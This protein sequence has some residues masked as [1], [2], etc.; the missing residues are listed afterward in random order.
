MDKKPVLLISSSQ[1]L[2]GAYSDDFAFIDQ[3]TDRVV[4]SPCTEESVA[5]IRAYLKEHPYI[6]TI[7]CRGFWYN[8]LMDTPELADNPSMRITRIDVDARVF[9][10]GF[11]ELT[12]LGY[13]NVILVHMSHY[14]DPD[15]PVSEPIESYGG[16]N[17][18]R[19]QFKTVEEGIPRFLDLVKRHPIDAI[20]GD[21]SDFDLTAYEELRAI[22]RIDY[23]IRKE[24]LRIQLLD[25]YHYANTLALAQANE[26]QLYDLKKIIQH[27]S[28]GII[29]FDEDGTILLHNDNALISRIDDGHKVGRPISDI[30]GLP[31]EEI[32]E[33]KA[34]SYMRLNNHGYIINVMELD[35]RDR[36]NYEM[37]LTSG[38]HAFDADMSARLALTKSKFPAR[39][40]FS[41]MIAVD[42]A[43]QKAVEAAKAFADY[44]ETVLI[45]GPTG[46]GKE[47]FASSIHNAS[48]RSNRPFVAINCATLSES[49]IDSELFGYEK[50]AFTGALTSGKHGLFEM[51]HRGT[52]FLDEISEIPIDLQTKLLRVLQ[53][54]TIRR[55]GGSEEIPIDVRIICATN[56]PLLKQCEKGLFRYDLYYRIA[57][58][59]INLPSLNDRPSDIVPLFTHFLDRNIKTTGRS[60]VWKNDNIFRCLTDYV[61]S[62]NIREL[63]NAALRTIILAPHRELTEADVLRAL[64]SSIEKIRPAVGTL[65]LSD[66]TAQSVKRPLSLGSPASE[67]SPA[68]NSDRVSRSPDELPADEAVSAVPEGSEISAASVSSQAGFV[69]PLT[70]DLNELEH[71]YLVYLMQ[72][73]DN[74]RDAVCDY[75]HISK[76]TLW[77]K[78]N[79]KK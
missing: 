26:Q 32:I 70:D 63:E 54:K 10:Q 25:A 45:T 37:I 71:Q 23:N 73:M 3:Y 79:Y 7:L 28:E 75:L 11:V 49:L 57:L 34:N 15:P 30:I 76:P 68:G 52:I 69:I 41:D 59:E 13:K 43:S 40:T 72:Q 44:D 22:P 42:P 2:R 77:R 27:A 9:M 19:A 14:R 18:Y 61:W 38:Q 39:Y 62:G 36:R 1:A 5:E 4:I 66:A 29:V 74:N 53:E 56:K 46:T 31:L 67:F 20:W 58:L 16:L 8:Q 35:L 24:A 65:T 55:I 17:I 48:R 78:L 50:G 47:L 64:P 21:I 51:A 33:M 6:S 60:H 12:R